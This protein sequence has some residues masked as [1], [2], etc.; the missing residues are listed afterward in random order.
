MNG[1]RPPLP[2]PDPARHPA[3][4]LALISELW[5]ANPRERASSGEVL[6]AIAHMMR[7]YL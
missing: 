3:E 6:K 2:P 5:A 4:L 1:S 7:L